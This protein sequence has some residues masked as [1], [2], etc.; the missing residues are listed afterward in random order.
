MKFYLHIGTNKTGTSSIQAFLS[1]N[2]ELLAQNGFLYPHTGRDYTYQAA[3]HPFAE[4]GRNFPRHM[5]DQ[6]GKMVQEAENQNLDSIILSSETF[7]TVHASIVAQ[8]LKGHEVQIIAFLRPHLEYYS[9]WYRE[10]VKS[11]NASA[12][13]E[14]FVFS[15]YQPYHYWLEYWTTAFGGP[16]I[17]VFEYNRDKLLFN[18]STSQLLHS[19]GFSKNVIQMLPTT[20]DNN[21]S[22]SGNLL[23]TKR[24]LNRH[25]SLTTAQSLI[26]EVLT[27]SELDPSFQGPLYVD[28]QT[29]E[30]VQ[31]LYYNDC[32]RVL[33]TF[34]VDLHREPK[35]M[36]GHKSPD[37]ATLPRQLH[38]MLSYAKE[39][40]FEFQKII[41]KYNVF[42]QHS[43]YPVL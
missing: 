43:N 13:L 19:L 42:E 16:N 9:S 23:Y 24:L 11:K 6:V 15:V 12:P 36:P 37:A 4:L 17:Q 31:K 25:I 8:A 21:P 7:H 41:E 38:D 20:K 18:S 2:P 35:E 3:H 26:P 22:I 29:A 33:D 28:Q 1:Q 27:L 32:Q 10:S 5:A 39:N 30:K 40:D 14:S 34:G